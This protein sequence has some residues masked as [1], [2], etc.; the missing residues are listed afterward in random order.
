MS[1][2]GRAVEEATGG[3]LRANALGLI[4]T[5]SLTAA[6]MAPAASLIALFGPIAGQVGLATG[7][8]ML[9][10]LLITLPSAISFGMMA[11]ELPSAGGVYA[12]A[13]QSLG[14]R[15]GRWVGIT[16]VCY[17]L[18]TMFFPPIVFGQL[19][20]SLIAQF[21]GHETLVLWVAGALTSLIIAA[22]SAYRGIAVSSALA[23]AMLL[24]QL[25]VMSALA[26]TFLVQG[27]HSGTLSVAPFTPSVS[28]NGWGG[29]LL[30]LPLVLLS[31]ACDAAT[32]ASEETK[33]ARRTIPLA[34]ILTLVLVGG[35]DV[36]AFGILAL[37]VPADELIRICTKDLDNALP[38]LAASVWGQAKI[39][40]TFVGLAA[41]IG[42]LV[43][44]STAASRLLYSLGRDRLLPTSLGQVDP[45]YRTPWNALHAA[46][47]LTAAATIVP[48]CI[49]GPV[50]TINWWGN[51]ISWFILAVYFTTNL[52]NIVFY[53][54]FRRARFSLLWNLL[55]P[56]IAMVSQL[57]VVWKVL[58]VQLWNAG[59][60]GRGAQAFIVASALLT[61]WYALRPR[62]VS[63][64]SAVATEGSERA[65][66][67]GAPA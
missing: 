62:P 31:L 64:Q 9:L 36:L 35:W 55:V 2:T 38:T 4:G 57:W 66:S 52:C 51:I 12:W 59:W 44:C 42:A 28:A 19:V 22:I 45:R 49:I 33:N 16:T 18:L 6:Y 40:V 8:V 47:V 1:D 50:P 34:I 14:E 7:F 63:P 54:R 10:G 13:D 37:S 26:V 11:K 23:L 17:Y 65:A 46:F 29:I 15:A 39:L 67:P 24:V 27:A 30:A 3:E 25:I 5:I 41:M 32:P 60:L 48:G 21:G 53:Y 43:P 61:A 58:V 56:A 20:N